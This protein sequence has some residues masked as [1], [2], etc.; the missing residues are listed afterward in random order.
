[1]K[2]DVLELVHTVILIFNF[3]Q[4][5]ENSV[6]LHFNFM[7]LLWNSNCVSLRGGG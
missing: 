4:T 2:W 3:G 5:I 6:R 7:A 1:M